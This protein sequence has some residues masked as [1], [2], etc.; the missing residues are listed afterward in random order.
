M[1]KN[2]GD[3]VGGGSVFEEVFVELVVVE[4]IFGNVILNQ[5]SEYPILPEESLE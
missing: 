1:I 2:P 3:E 4:D 5:T